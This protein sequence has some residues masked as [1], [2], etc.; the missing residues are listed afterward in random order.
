[1]KFSTITS[2][3]LA[4]AGLALAAPSKTLVKATAIEATTGDNGITTPLPIQPGMVDNCDLFHL[5]KKDTGCLQ[6]ATQY[7]ITFEQFKEWNPT[8]GDD[9]S[10]LWADANVCVRT[11]GYVYPVS[12]ACFGSRDVLPWGKNKAAA[13]TA[14]HD[15]CYTKTT[16]GFYDI[17]ETRTGCINAP[18]GG[19]KF[20]F[21]ISTKHGRRVG[22]TS[23]KC[24]KFLDLGINGCPE[25]AQT[26]TEGWSMETT[27]ETGKCKA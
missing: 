19:G 25:G 10:T 20:V 17:Y 16:T 26:N 24:E 6:V 27:F 8:V 14:A 11:I 4:N 15:W 9:C 21:E 5:V 13:L 12:V 2:L 23:S 18:S 3:F 22:L 7:G 1:M